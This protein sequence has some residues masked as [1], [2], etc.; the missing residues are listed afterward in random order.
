MTFCLLPR[1]CRAQ[2]VCVLFGNSARC[3]HKYD[4]NASPYRTF[5]PASLSGLL[6]SLLPSM[7]SQVEFLGC[8]STVCKELLLINGTWSF[9]GK[10]QVR[11]FIVV[12]VSLHIVVG[13]KDMT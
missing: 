10:A 3:L 11:L 12:L 5:R 6:L 9:V 1:V 13:C 2:P 7:S 4:P 8:V